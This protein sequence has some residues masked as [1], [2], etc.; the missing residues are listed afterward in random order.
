MLEIGNGRMTPTEYR[1]HFSLWALLSAPLIAG[2]DLRDM[3]PETKEI[4]LN[5]E[6][7]AVNQDKLGKAGYR[8]AQQEE[9]EVW[10]RPLDKGAYAVGLFNRGAAEADVTVKWADLKLS[11]RPKVRDLWA[12][13]ERGHVADGFTAKVAPHGVVMI[14]VSR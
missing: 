10:V 1:T 12:H 11:G 3:T 5:K 14:R 9:T 6:V 7:I 2:N 4:L 13:A 8:L